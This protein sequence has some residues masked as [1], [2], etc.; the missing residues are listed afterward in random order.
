M[1]SI[2]PPLF[3]QSVD[4]TEKDE[5]LLR[6]FW[7]RA[8]LK[9]ELDQLRG[10]SARLLEEVRR[11]EATTLR[12][13]QRLEQLETRLGNPEHSATVV[14][15]YQLRA[16]WSRCE[17]RLAAMATEL[18]R[19][20]FDNAK[21]EFVEAFRQRVGQS[22]IGLQAQLKEATVKGDELSACI[23]ALR[24]KRSFCRGFW[25]FLKRR[26]LTAEIRKYRYEHREVRLF[27]EELANDIRE[28]NAQE[29]PEFPGLSTE[30]KRSVNAMLIA[31][32]QEFYLHFADRQL[33]VMA[34]DAWLRQLL[35]ANY[36]SRRECRALSKYIE[37]RMKAL[38]DDDDFRAQV[39]RRAAYLTSRLEYRGDG[40]SVPMAASTG[41]I[42]VLKADGRCKSEVDVN[43]LAD[44][45]WDIFAVLLV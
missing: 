18:E 17:L 24:E 11:Q 19:A 23:K 5:Q 7:N 21:R 40:D 14:T 37:S 20:R 9:K 3:P 2:A 6:L 10:D 22:L 29:A 26:R 25:N 1:A 36:G 35:D 8:E 39:K 16:I 12:V 27:I 42:A 32:A 38:A 30:A 43:V 31:C 4:N 45:Y 44:E 34:R 28:R 33:A 13:Q 41:K 15:Y